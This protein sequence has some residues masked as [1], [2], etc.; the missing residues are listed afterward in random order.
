MKND[1]TAQGSEQKISVTVSPAKKLAKVRIG[2]KV[3]K[4]YQFKKDVPFEVVEREKHGYDY[5][6]WSVSERDYTYT[7]KEKVFCKKTID[8]IKKDTLKYYL[9]NQNL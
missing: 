3:V 8:Q 2:G 6:A 1:K 7:V 5:G 4:V 9:Q